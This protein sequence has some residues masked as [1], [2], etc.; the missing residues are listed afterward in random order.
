MGK[1]IQANLAEMGN[2]DKYNA[3]TNKLVQL[4]WTIPQN[5]TYYQ[6]FAIAH[7]NDTDVADENL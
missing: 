1:T 4:G 3:A 2:V 7:A 6:L 5:M